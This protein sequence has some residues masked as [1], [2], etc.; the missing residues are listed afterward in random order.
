LRWCNCVAVWRHRRH[1][2]VPSFWPPCERCVYWPFLCVLRSLHYFKAFF[3][4][5]TSEELSGQ[6]PV[7]A[8][9]PRRTGASSVSRLPAVGR[10]PATTAATG[11][12]ADARAGARNP[13]T[14]QAQVP[15]LPACEARPAGSQSSQSSNLDAPCPGMTVT[16]PVRLPLRLPAGLP[17]AYESCKPQRCRRAVRRT[18]PSEEKTSRSASPC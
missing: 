4:F 1:V 18:P 12:Q 3:F 6:Q 10:W 7:W 11:S 8:W 16:T 13:A 15:I 2:L 14:G 17:F 5:L 9:R